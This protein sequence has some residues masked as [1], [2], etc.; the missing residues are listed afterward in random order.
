MEKLVKYWKE[1][2][3]FDVVYNGNGFCSYILTGEEFYISN[4]YVED[5]TKGQSYAFFEYIKLLAK[6]LGATY[7]SSNLDLN[8]YNKDTYHNKVMIQLRHGFK[9]VNVTDKRITV[10]KELY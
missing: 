5:R 3:G 8:E 2:E 10:L 1:E 6:E 7:L 9:I 4:I